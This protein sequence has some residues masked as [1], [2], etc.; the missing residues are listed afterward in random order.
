MELAARNE[1]VKALEAEVEEKSWR[2]IWDSAAWAGCNGSWGSRWG[3][4]EA[5]AG[6]A[7]RFSRTSK[8]GG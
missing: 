6:F 1:K 5:W 2:T 4:G 7:R 3:K 8:N